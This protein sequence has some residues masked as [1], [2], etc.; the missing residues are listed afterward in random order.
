LGFYTGTELVMTSL[1]ISDTLVSDSL[2]LPEH[3]RLRDDPDNESGS[4]DEDATD[5]I[6]HGEDNI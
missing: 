1:E 6:F 2:P 5:L 4:Y 3:E